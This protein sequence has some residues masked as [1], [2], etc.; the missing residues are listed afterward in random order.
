MARSGTPWL[1]S[2][3]ASQQMNKSFGISCDTRYDVARSEEHAKGAKPDSKGHFRIGR[4]KETESSLDGRAG[5]MPG[6]KPDS[7]ECQPVR[8]RRRF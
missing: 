2:K 3:T 1:Y 7:R 5:E 8:T 6:V 4:S